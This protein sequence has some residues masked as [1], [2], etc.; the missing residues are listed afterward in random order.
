MCSVLGIEW[1]VRRTQF[2]FMKLT[3]LTYGEDGKLNKINYT[4]T[5]EAYDSSAPSCGN[6]DPDGGFHSIPS[7]HMHCASSK[8]RRE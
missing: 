4:V 2:T 1:W 8:Q 5:R 3:E 6:G 7:V